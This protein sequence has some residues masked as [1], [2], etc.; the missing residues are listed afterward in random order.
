[1]PALTKLK[2]DMVFNAR[3]AGLLEAMKSIAAQQFQALERALKSNPTLFEAIEMIAATFDPQS[4]SHPFMQAEGPVGVIA[5]TS[6]TGLVGG[7][8][9][10]V[11]LRSLQEYHRQPGE[12]MVVGERGVAAAREHGVPCHAFASAGDAARRQRAEEI[13]TYAL[14]RVVSGALGALSIVYPRALSFTVQRVEL[15]RVLPCSAWLQAKE[16]PRVR[17]GPVLMESA[18]S[19]VLE[20]LV[21][22]WLGQTLV[23]VLGMSRLAEF[24]ARSIHLEGSSQELQRRGKQMQLRYFKERREVIDR[25]MRELFSAKAIFGKT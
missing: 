5:V 3:L 13:R 11:M 6:D 2:Q 21:W 20:Y 22:L 16:A 19:S 17:G 24:A 9:H 23:D 15:I 8:N 25:N 10:Q 7:L 4:V 14:N 18:V 1:M 12:L